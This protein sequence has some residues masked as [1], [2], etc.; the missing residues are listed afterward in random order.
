MTQRTDTV[1]SGRVDL[2]G[3]RLK[4]TRETSQILHAGIICL[5]ALALLVSA[6][7]SSD[8]ENKQYRTKVD[9][10]LLGY[11]KVQQVYV[12]VVLATQN[13]Q[14]EVHKII[15]KLGGKVHG[16]LKFVNGYFAE[17]PGQNIDE[18]AESN[19]ISYISY[20]GQG[21]SS[22][23]KKRIYVN[24]IKGLQ[25]VTNNK[26][27]THAR[28][29]NMS[30][31]PPN[32]KPFDQR[33][34]VN[35]ATKRAYQSG[36]IIVIAAGNAGPGENTLIPWSVAHW[37]ISV[38]AASDDGKRLYEHS[39]VG[40]PNDPY[41]RP[42]VVAPGIDIVG[43]WP[44]YIPKSDSQLERDRRFIPEDRL[45]R[46]TVMSGTSQAAA[47]VS[48]C[49]LW[50][51]PF[52]EALRDDLNDAELDQLDSLAPRH[53][54]AAAIL[55]TGIDP[56]HE[57]FGD[58]SPAPPRVRTSERKAKI[59][60]LLEF[61]KSNNIPYSVQPSPD[62]IKKMLVDLAK[63]MPGYA[64]HQIGNGFVSQ[65]VVKQYLEEFG[66]MN[67]CKLFC[68]PTGDENIENL[69]QRLDKQIGPLATNEEVEEIIEVTSQS[70]R[71]VIGRVW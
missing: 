66:I 63:P 36:L 31:G 1:L 71:L 3:Y 13:H 33:D 67:F 12:I 40:K 70:V 22:N 53:P 19:Y 6:N 38:G 4:R 42:T 55:D 56:S 16:Y 51:I 23:S 29:I 10:E 46:Y 2:R 49:I 5:L 35:L 58:W 27:N 9:P 69:L 37:V 25:W 28:L 61:L 8:G 7:S 59:S 65:K 34:P 11:T 45:D 30:I 15:N 54:I 32:P 62:I 24:V 26:D 48:R 64:P 57:A 44:S 41:Y 60:K 20:A 39:S 68:Q 21:K 50:L 47:H 14:N 43:P 52:I 18:L 17:L